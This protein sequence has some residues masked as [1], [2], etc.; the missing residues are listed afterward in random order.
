MTYEY[1]MDLAVKSGS[2]RMIAT[3]W[4]NVCRTFNYPLMRKINLAHREK[5]ATSVRSL[6][7][8]RIQPKIHEPHVLLIMILNE[9]ETT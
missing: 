4:Y 8:Q 3:I 7:K 9:M 5:I 1:L 2:H 6:T